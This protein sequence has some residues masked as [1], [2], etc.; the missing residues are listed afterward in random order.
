MAI[1]PDRKIAFIILFIFALLA[2]L[3]Y[4]QEPL[5]LCHTETI[6]GLQLVGQPPPPGYPFHECYLDVTRQIPIPIWSF[7]VL[8]AL[9]LFLFVVSK[10]SCRRWSWFAGI[11]LILGILFYLNSPY[12]KG[13]GIM[14]G[15]VI[16]KP[17]IVRIW[18]FLLAVISALILAVSEGVRFIKYL[19]REHR[20]R[21]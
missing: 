8:V 19:V 13:V 2:V 18:F 5:D 21:M 7:G 10:K 17:D 9:A 1:A 14:G 15:L 12:D 11:F 20:R 3:L 4:F 6:Y 16:T